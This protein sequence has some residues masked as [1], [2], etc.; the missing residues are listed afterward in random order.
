VFL[1]ICRFH[2]ERANRRKHGQAQPAQKTSLPPRGHFST[3]DAVEKLSSV[4]G[5][6][7][8]I[9]S[10]KSRMSVFKTICLCCHFER[11]EKSAF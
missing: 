7:E 1:L 9:L 8:V 11:S 2:K 5:R 10:A 4:L 6:I 3:A